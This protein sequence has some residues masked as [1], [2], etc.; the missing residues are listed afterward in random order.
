MASILSVHWH[1]INGYGQNLFSPPRKYGYLM[2]PIL[3]EAF[4]GFAEAF[5]K[6]YS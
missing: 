4:S 6:K 2:I 3:Q 5:C 1:I